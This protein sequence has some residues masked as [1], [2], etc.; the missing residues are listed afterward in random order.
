MDKS[1]NNDSGVILPVFEPSERRRRSLRNGSPLEQLHDV[2]VTSVG[3]PP[4]VGL[5]RR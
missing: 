3:D 4:M 5:K 1:L 2:F